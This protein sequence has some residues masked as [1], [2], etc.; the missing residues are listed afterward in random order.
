MKKLW[1]ILVVI[2]GILLGWSI[3]SSQNQQPSSQLT[4]Q[5]L[6][7]SS[8]AITI[9]TG[10]GVTRYRPDNAVGKTA[11]EATRQATG[12]RIETQGEGENAFVVLLVGRKASA[13]K[14]E[15]WELVISGKPAQVGAGT[16]VVKE[17]DLLEWR[18]STY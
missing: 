17:G 7:S 15:F 13:E 3:L 2:A 18:I 12:G 16:Y 9:D 4:I 1:P 14:R 6:K 5:Q 11:L 8:V 10:E